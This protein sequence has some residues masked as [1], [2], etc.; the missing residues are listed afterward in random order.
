MTAEETVTVVVGLTA[1][2][3]SPHILCIMVVTFAR[4]GEN[5]VLGTIPW[6]L[7]I[8]REVNGK[9]DRDRR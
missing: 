9:G 3:M 2:S 4:T 1:Y 7:Q 8:Q 5:N 6:S